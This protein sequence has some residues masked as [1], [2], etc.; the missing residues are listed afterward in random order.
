LTLQN[1]HP[2][3]YENYPASTDP[4]QNQD[5]VGYLFNFYIHVVVTVPNPAHRQLKTRMCSPC[6]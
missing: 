6:D 2:Y 5:E 1:T 3:T 4:S